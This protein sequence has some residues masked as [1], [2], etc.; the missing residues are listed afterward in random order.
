MNGTPKRTLPSTE[1]TKE[2]H[3]DEVTALGFSPDGK[4]LA[5]GGADRAVILWNVETGR[6]IATP[7]T[8]FFHKKVLGVTFDAS[9]HWL[10][11]ASANMPTSPNAPAT[12]ASVRGEI[13]RVYCVPGLASKVIAY[14]L[15]WPQAE[16]TI[17]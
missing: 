4:V 2:G 9:G 13:S 6:K 12:A 10:A 3:S 7:H 1:L 14:S 16:T 5:T 11:A 17:L 15:G 8:E